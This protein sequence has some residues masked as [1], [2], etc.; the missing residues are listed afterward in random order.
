MA[1]CIDCGQLKKDK[2]GLRCYSCASHFKMLGKKPWNKDLHTGL[3]PKTAFKKDHPSWNKGK[4]GLKMENHPSWKG[5]KS[6]SSQGYI[7]ICVGGGRKLEHRLVMEHKISRELQRHEQ[8]HHI[9]GNKMNNNL[10][11]LMLFASEKEHTLYHYGN[12]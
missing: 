8:V 9:D 5:G 10:D 3:I 6:I 7:T 11:N 2:R 4:E 1:T 12:C